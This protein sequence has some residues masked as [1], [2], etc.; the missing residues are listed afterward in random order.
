MADSRSDLEC[1]EILIAKG[2]C[3]EAVDWSRQFGSDAERAWLECV[4]SDW[5][6]WIMGHAGIDSRHVVRAAAEIALSVIHL[7]RTEDRGVCQAT[8]AAALS[9]CDG[10]GSAADAARAAADADAAHAAAY[11]AYAARAAADAAAHADAAAIV[12]RCVPWSV[13]RAKVIP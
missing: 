4:R 1:A 6:F 12:R 8:I 3:N 9:W 11:A 7:T 2:A 5:M 10:I 13:L